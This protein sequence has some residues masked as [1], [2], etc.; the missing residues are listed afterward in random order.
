MRLVL[1][2]DTAKAFARLGWALGLEGSLAMAGVAQ[3]QVTCSLDLLIIERPKVYPGVQRE[4]PNDLIDVALMAGRMIER[5]P[6]SALRTPYP[7]DWKGQVPKEIHN[8]RVL[9]ALTCTERKIVPNNHN[10]IDA[11]GLYLWAIGRMKR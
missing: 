9:K 3:P 2:I 4:D 5:F 7:Q 11:A 6:H 1:A 8:R 10:A